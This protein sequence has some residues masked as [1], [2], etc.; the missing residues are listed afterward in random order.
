MKTTFEKNIIFDVSQRI[1]QVR[2]QS[3]AQIIKS[4]G[5]SV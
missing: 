1:V 4:D 2:R 5:G 3:N